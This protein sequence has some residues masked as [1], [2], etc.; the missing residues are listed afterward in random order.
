MRFVAD[1]HV[2][3]RNTTQKAGR[4]FLMRFFQVNDFAGLSRRFFRLIEPSDP[5]LHVGA[6]LEQVGKF[7]PFRRPYSTRK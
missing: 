6:A 4:T 1:P 7:L 3:Q 2:H 5:T